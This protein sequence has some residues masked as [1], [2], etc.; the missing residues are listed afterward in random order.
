MPF[1]MIYVSF[2]IVLNENRQEPVAVFILNHCMVHS[3]AIYIREIVVMRY[4]ASMYIVYTE[5]VISGNGYDVYA[6]AR[7]DNSIE[8]IR[9]F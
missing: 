3:T 8:Q 2:I 4:R 9:C 1:S 5:A 7:Y 6:A